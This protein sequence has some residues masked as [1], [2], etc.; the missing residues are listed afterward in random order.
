MLKSDMITESTSGETKNMKE[1]LT[2]AEMTKGFE[3]WS[4]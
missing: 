4:R 3:L 1:R 2:L